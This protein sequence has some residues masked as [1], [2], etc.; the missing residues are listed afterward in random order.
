MCFSSRIATHIA[1]ADDD[2]IFTHLGF[3]CFGCLQ[4][5]KSRDGPFI[6]RNRQASG[7]LGSGGN[8]DK[9][10]ILFELDDVF[11][12][13]GLL[14]VYLGNHLFD[15]LHLFGNHLFGNTALRN[16][17]RYSPAE[18]LCHLVNGD[19]MPLQAQLPGN[20]DPGRPAADNR[21]FFIALRWKIGQFGLE[22]RLAQL[23]DVHR[24]HC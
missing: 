23:G 7:F 9:I 3:V 22:T 24:C 18:C 21:D 4:K 11:R 8:D 6:P 2:Y 12:A 15:A 13:Q 19:L 20:G 1:G 14:K 17:L 5:I 16:N 10:K